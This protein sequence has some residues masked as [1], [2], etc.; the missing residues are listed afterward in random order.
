MRLFVLFLINFVFSLLFSI[1]PV[2]PGPGPSPN[3]P[4][5]RVVINPDTIQVQSGRTVELNCVVHGG[6]ASTSIYWIQEEP[7]RVK[8]RCREANQSIIFSFL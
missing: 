1:E 5:L 3:A 6:D 2:A 4:E 8:N 7:E